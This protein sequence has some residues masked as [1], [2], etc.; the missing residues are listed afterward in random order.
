MGDSSAFRFDEVAAR[1]A[2]ARCLLWEP[3]EEA[4]PVGYYCGMLDPAGNQVEFSFG[5]PLG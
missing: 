4:W 2:D 1:A 5:Q 3:R